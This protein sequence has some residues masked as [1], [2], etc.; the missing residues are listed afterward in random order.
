MPSRKQE[1]YRDLL[2][3]VLPQLRMRP[4]FRDW[5]WGQRSRVQELAQLVHDLP[6]SILEPDFGEHDLW[7]LNV[8]AK[9]YF[10]RCPDDGLIRDKVVELFRLVPDRL[11]GNLKWQGPTGPLPPE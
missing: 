9:S 5:F 11:R 7:F 4:T 10:E 1:I 8:H 3:W 6:V 2:W